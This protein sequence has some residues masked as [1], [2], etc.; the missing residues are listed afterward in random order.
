MTK[1]KSNAALSKAIQSAHAVDCATPPGTGEH[2][3]STH[4]ESG[5]V[6]GQRNLGDPG[7][8]RWVLPIGKATVGHETRLVPPS[9][10]ASMHWATRSRWKKAFEEQVFWAVRE[11]KV[12]KLE[13]II[14]TAEVRQCQ[15]P[16]LDNLAASMKPLI[17]GLVLAEVIPDD[18]P[19]YL[20]ELRLRSVHAKTKGE[21]QVILT[22]EKAP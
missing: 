7:M 9:L 8:T 11:A 2:G 15:E 21:E 5:E 6:G 4:L 13:R 14:L 19:K 16:D 1:K 18:H 20:T 17:D 12:P 22:I 10:N 3:F